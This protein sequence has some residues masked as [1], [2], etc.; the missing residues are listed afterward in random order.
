MGI[1]TNKSLLAALAFA[2][3]FSTAAL[4][5]DEGQ[6]GEGTFQPMTFGA[7]VDFDPNAPL[8]APLPPGTFQFK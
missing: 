8:P 4:A 2:S 1:V 3:M 6:S 5:T 7:S